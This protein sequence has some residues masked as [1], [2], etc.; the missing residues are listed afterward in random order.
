MKY[1][2]DKLKSVLAT[3]EILK[4]KFPIIQL[5]GSTCHISSLQIIDKGVYVLNDIYYFLYP[6]TIKQLKSGAIDNL[7]NGLTMIEELKDVYQNH[8][9]STED[10]INV[11]KSKQKKKGV[12]NVFVG[13]AGPAR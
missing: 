11:V 9:R 6:K 1:Y 12:K 8:E 3:K 5:M 2:D 13:Q 4:V 10:E 7:I